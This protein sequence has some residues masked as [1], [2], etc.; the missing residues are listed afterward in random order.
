[1]SKKHLE[2]ICVGSNPCVLFLYMSCFPVF[3]LM[4]VAFGDN[5]VVC[6]FRVMLLVICV[7]VSMSWGVLESIGDKIAQA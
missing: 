7:G 3:L 4:F 5:D 6:S 1:M 2:R